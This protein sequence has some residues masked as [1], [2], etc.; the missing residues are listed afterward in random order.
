[1]HCVEILGTSHIARQSIIA[2][3][4][5]I[6]EFKPDIIAVEL[7]KYRLPYLFEPRS[8]LRLQDIARLG[9]MG[10]LFNA[11]GGWLQKK[12][13]EKV[14]LMPGADMRAAIK[15]AQFAKIPVALIDRPI[16]I[17][18]QRLSTEMGFWEKLKFISYLISGFIMPPPKWLK[19]D[20]STAPEEKMVARMTFELRHKFP[21]IYRIL[22]KERNEYMAKQIHL[23]IS[24]NPDKKILVVVGAGH[25]RGL[26]RI[27]ASP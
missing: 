27:L 9:F 3:R 11:I 7:D 4:N 13:G 26:Q 23:L 14:G 5:K 18:M 8:K 16:M 22:V 17:T 15:A 21:T 24:E 6:V 25:V 12:L 1:M 20:L 2:I 10:F 19:I